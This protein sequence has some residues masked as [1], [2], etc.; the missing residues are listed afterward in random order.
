MNRRAALC[1]CQFPAGTGAILRFYCLVFDRI[2]NAKTSLIKPN[3]KYEIPN[4]FYI[5]IIDFIKQNLAAYPA[6][7]N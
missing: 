1:G 2:K 6:N 4:T 7:G 5:I 3:T